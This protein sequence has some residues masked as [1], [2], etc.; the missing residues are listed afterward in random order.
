M[1]RYAECLDHLNFVHL[2]LFRIS[3]LWRP[4]PAKPAF[5]NLAVRAA[6]FKTKNPSPRLP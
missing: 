3:N 2:V 1:T 6:R 5:Q 4:F